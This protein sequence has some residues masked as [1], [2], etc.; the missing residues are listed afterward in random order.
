MAAGGPI[1]GA[2]A[3]MSPGGPPGGGLGPAINGLALSVKTDAIRLEI[4]KLHATSSFA[5]GFHHARF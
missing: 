3:A 1:R 2:G 4:L 5:V